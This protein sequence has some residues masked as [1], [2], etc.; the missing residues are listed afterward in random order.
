MLDACALETRDDGW[1]VVDRVEE[2]ETERETESC[3]V[4]PMCCQ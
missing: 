3:L 2:S 4:W 1:R